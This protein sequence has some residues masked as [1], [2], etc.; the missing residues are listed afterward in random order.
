MNKKNLF[1]LMA[2]LLVSILSVGFTACS[3]DDDDNPSE[4]QSQSTTGIKALTSDKAPALGWNGDSQNGILTFAEEPWE[5]DEGNIQPY[6]AFEFSNAQCNEAVYDI[7]FPSVQ[8]AQKFEAIC[9]DG[10]WAEDID[11]DDD[12]APLRKAI[13]P[14]LTRAQTINYKDLSLPAKRNGKVVYF[15]MDTFKKK[16]AADIKLLINYWCDVNANMPNKVICGT[17]D[18]AKGK[19]NNNNV[20]GVGIVYD[21]KATFENDYLT[22]LTGTMTCPNATWARLMY[23]VVEDVN[24]EVSGFSGLSTE[25]KLNGKTITE[26]ANVEPGM[27]PRAYVEQM[28]YVYDVNYSYPVFCFF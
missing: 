10:T 14:I 19:Y 2:I 5:T 23:E 20:F 26:E 1:Q 13:K 18:A 3:S 27:I 22:K 16:S 12:Y 15:L 25:V 24:D 17:W 11:D 4:E 7:V 8:L 28:M 9:K 21:I 6:Y